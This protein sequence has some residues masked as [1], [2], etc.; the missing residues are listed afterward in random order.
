MFVRCRRFASV[1]VGE[2]TVGFYDAGVVGGVGET[3]APP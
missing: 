3:V 2:L 1:V